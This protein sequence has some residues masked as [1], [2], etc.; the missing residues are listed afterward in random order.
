MKVRRFPHVPPRRRRMVALCV[1][2]LTLVLLLSACGGSEPTPQVLIVTATFTPEPVVVVITATFTPTPEALETST[3]SAPLPTDTQPPPPDTP[4]SKPLSKASATTTAEPAATPQPMATNTPVPPSPTATPLPPSPTPMPPTPTRMPA[5]QP[6]SL[7]SY[8]VVYTGFK[9]P[10]LQDYSLWAMNGDGSDVFKIE[11]AG[12]ASEPAFSPDG[13]KLAFYHWT[14]GLYIWDLNRE[15]SS[16]IIFD[17][18]AAFPTWSP[19]GQRLAYFVQAGQRWVYIVNADGSDNHQL[20]PGLRPSWSLQGGFIAYDTCENNQCGIYR[21]NPDGGGKRQLTSD[22]GGGPAVSPD[23]MRIAYWSRADGDFEVYL[24]NADSSGKR[25]V[26]NNVGNDA[27]PAWSPDGKYIYYL[28]DQNG[29]GW[30]VMAMNADGSNPRK[31]VNTSVGSDPGRGWQYQRITV[32][33][34]K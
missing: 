34:N 11:G 17:S 21:I 16:H 28:S 24:V 27:L 22:G 18:N 26:T 4:T 8:F 7:K 2:A 31:I 10:D 14:D 9:G 6:T 15:T 5:A 25:Q 30:A 1:V 3:P 33:W 20:T 29:K 19:N 32:T 12:Q 23:G 13:G